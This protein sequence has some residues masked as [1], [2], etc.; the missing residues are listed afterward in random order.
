MKNNL[1]ARSKWTSSVIFF[2][3][4]RAYRDYDARAPRPIHYTTEWFVYKQTRTQTLTQAQ[5]HSTLV[6]TNERFTTRRHIFVGIKYRSTVKVV[7]TMIRLDVRFLALPDH[8]SF[9]CSFPASN[10][11]LELLEHYKTSDKMKVANDA[12][13]QVLR[14]LCA[15]SFL[16]SHNFRSWKMFSF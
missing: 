8:F 13:F 6:I 10:S 3:F 2:R 14:F 7:K 15:I 12:F 5:A 4:M 16:T 1:I 9:S 11:L